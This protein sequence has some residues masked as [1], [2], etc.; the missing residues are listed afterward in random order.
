MQR[1][2]PN[3]ESL[4][5]KPAPRDEAAKIPD[6]MARPLLLQQASGQRPL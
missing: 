2:H 4:M 3:H 1:R 5:E 6:G